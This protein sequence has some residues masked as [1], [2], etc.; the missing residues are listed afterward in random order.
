MK[1]GAPE[2]LKWLLLILPLA[3]LFIMLHHR[4][5]ARL[6]Q[7]IAAGSWRKVIAG[8][9]TGRGARR[10]ALRTA[11]LFF[12][13]LALTRPQWGTRW[14]EVKHRG[15][16]IIIVLDTSRSM[17]AEDIKPNRLQQAK[18]AVRDFARKL[19]GD[20]VGLVAFAGGSFLQC[21]VTVDYAA[22]TM[23]LNDLYAGIIPRGGTAIE[24]ALRTAINNFDEQSSADR[25]IILITD[26]EDHEG[27]PLR[28]AEE[29][30]R[31]NIKLFSVGVGTPDGGLIPAEE[32]YVKNTQGL[33]V[34]SSLNEALLEK[35]ASGSGGFYVRSAP[36]DFGLD[37]IYKFGIAGL[38]RDEQETRMAKVYEERFMW[39]AAAALL[40][41]TAEGLS[42]LRSPKA[43]VLILLC[44]APRTDAASWTKEFRRGE[45]TNALEM[46]TGEEAKPADVREYNRGVIL[47]RMDDFSAA[48]KAFAN[49]TAQATGEKLRQRALYNRGTALFRSAHAV[50]SDPEKPAAPFDLAAQAAAQFEEALLL[51][52]DDEP[53]KKNLERSVM[54]IIAGRIHSARTLIQSA[55]ELLKEFQAKSAQTNYSSAKNLL[56]PVLADFSPENP[57][58]TRLL[59][60]AEERLAFLAL[61]VDL[62][63]QEMAAAKQFIDEYN[64][65]EAADIMLDDKP[66]RRLAFDLDEKLAQEFSQL[67][68]NNMNVIHIVYP[69]NPLKP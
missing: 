28:V 36:G 40:L 20:R 5:A 50:Q 16:D 29:L 25:V 22:F 6:A 1:F 68:Q 55:D 2:F 4:R 47:Y 33:V 51:N 45:Y 21:P 66:Q 69:D 48:E 59:Q 56:T 65:K 60:H 8:F 30:R 9:S 58:A 18:W 49:A 34:K 61:S 26:G 3:A 44:F 32:G 57:D 67:I 39:F 15:L 63:K 35:L 14:E 24:Q 12:V 64:Y 31:K 27:D 37:R 62:T 46:L 19:N 10:T 38:Q 7:L 54:F 23:M 13:L 17:L 52:P 11:A 41:L 53:A 42:L 43:L